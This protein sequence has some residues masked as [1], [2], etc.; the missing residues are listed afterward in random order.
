M[1]NGHDVN[2]RHGVQDESSTEPADAENRPCRFRL[3]LADEPRDRDSGLLRGKSIQ[4]LQSTL[5][6][7]FAV[8]HGLTLTLKGRGGNGFLETARKLSLSMSFRVDLAIEYRS[9]AKI[10]EV[11]LHRLLGFWVEG[12]YMLVLGLLS[13]PRRTDYLFSLH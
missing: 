5:D 1:G 8:R 2:R 13:I 10:A 7:F 3:H 9:S 4:Q 12:R 6:L 11:D